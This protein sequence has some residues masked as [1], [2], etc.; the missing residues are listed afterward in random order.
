MAAAE[1]RE[2]GPTMDLEVAIA[3]AHTSRTCLNDPR[4][5]AVR[6]GRIPGVRA[7]PWD[8]PHRWGISGFEGAN[9]SAMADQHMPSIRQDR[10]PRKLGR[11]AS[12]SVTARSA[13]SR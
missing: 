10:L 9:I 6:R 13:T 1:S 11:S 3:F 12:R 5:G 8:A 4:T 7:L 2:P